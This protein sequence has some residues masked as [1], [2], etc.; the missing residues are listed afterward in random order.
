MKTWHNVVV[1]ALM[2]AAGAGCIQ[3]QKTLQLKKDGSGTLV[4]EIYMS[5]QLTGMLEQMTGGLAQA[6]EKNSASMGA[7]NQAQV[8]AALDPLTLFKGD[9]AKRTAE[10]GPGVQLVSTHAKTNDKG[11][12]GYVAT[13]SFPD[14]T[15][16]HLTLAAQDAAGGML[17]AEQKK[18]APLLLEFRQGPR[19]EITFRQQP[20]APAVPEGRQAGAAETMPGVEAL[21]AALLGPMLQGLRLSFVVEVEG[22]ITRTSSHYQEGR[23]RVVLMDLPMDKVLAQAA[24][25]KLLEGGKN[26]PEVLKKLRDLKIPGLAIEDLQSGVSIEWQ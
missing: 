5:P 26:D 12:K 3:D 8:K 11:W 17:G 6:L 10:L 7:V 22:K 16:L 4:E 24:G 20:A 14:V 19:S 15:K 2:A 18:E 21:P 23:H 1:L 9:I 25:A 13:F